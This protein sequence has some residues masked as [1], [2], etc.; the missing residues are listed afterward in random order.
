MKV[1][2]VILRA[3][4]GKLKW[5]EAAEIIGISDRTMRRWRER[6]EEDGY[7]GLYDYRKR[8]PSPKRIAVKTLETVLQLY[9]ENY[10]D[11]NVRHFH[12][13]LREE[14][15]IELSYTWVKLALQGAGLVK[16]R[17]RRGTHRR[18]RPRRPLP[19]MLLH[20]DASKHAWLG[21]GRYYDL[22][23]ILDDATSEIYYARLVK[24]EG[25]RTLMPAVRQVVESKGIFCAL[26]SDRASHFFVTPKAGGKVDP[27]RVTQFGR[28]LQ[29]LGIQMI[30]AYSPQARGRMERNY[31]TWQGRFPQ[32]LRVRKIDSVEAA[33]R[34]LSE[35]YI[36]AF[37]QRFRVPAAETGSAFV[38]TRRKD[39]D[40]VF[41][42]QHR[43][44][45][46]QDNTITLDNRTLQIESNRWRD[47]LAGCKVT[48]YEFLDGNLAVRYG[49]H[50]VARFEAASL[51]LQP[52]RGSGSARPLGHK[53]Q[54]A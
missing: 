52:V 26:Y 32:E 27:S 1:K 7:S 24:E 50:E 45:V 20:I 34:F 23:T 47:T 10:F 48:V 17:R 38:R 51:A 28:A 40:W 44:T 46:N 19:G 43:R 25:T 36:A 39:L 37:N 22:V 5:W 6:Y 13:K 35:E 54:V 3:M 30:P 12:E 33:N 18:R 29:E 15:Q 53:R 21:E 14:H 9:R 2:E 49:P 41:A 11:F 42:L 16:K 8:Q 4:A 31:R